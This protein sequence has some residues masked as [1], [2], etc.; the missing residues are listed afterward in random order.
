MQP[1]T[2]NI[3]SVMKVMHD[4]WPYITKIAD[5]SNNS[6]AIYRQIILIFDKVVQ[7][8]TTMWEHY[9]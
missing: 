4:L 1:H 2:E 3:A 7:F 8:F 6:I 9:I 5:I